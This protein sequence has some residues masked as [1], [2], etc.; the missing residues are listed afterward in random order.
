[1]SDRPLRF[2]IWNPYIKRFIYWGFIDGDFV[3]PEIKNEALSEQ[4]TGL[5]DKYGKEI[6]EG[7]KVEREWIS[8]PHP[9]PVHPVVWHKGGFMVQEDSLQWSSFDAEDLIVV[10]HIHWVNQILNTKGR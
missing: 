6:W 7:D 2:R 4:F 10:G 8:I 1:M 9:R 5:L 3:P